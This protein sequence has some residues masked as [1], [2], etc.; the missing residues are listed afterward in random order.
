[1]ESKDSGLQVIPFIRAAKAEGNFFE[2]AGSLPRRELI[3]AAGTINM[4]LNPE[5]SDDEI[6]MSLYLAI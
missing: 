1:M 3:D 5:S 4:G 2:V 6:L